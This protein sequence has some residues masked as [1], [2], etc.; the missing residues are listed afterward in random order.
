[1]KKDENEEAANTGATSSL[2]VAVIV[3][4]GV[5]VLPP[6]ANGAVVVGG[7]NATAFA[8]YYAARA[9]VRATIHHDCGIG[10]DEAGISGLP[11]ADE[12]G[13]AMAAVAT[14]SARAGD[15]EDMLDRGII[16][17]VNKLAAKCGVETGQTVAQ[18]VELLKSASWPH[19]DAEAP[20][21][22][23]IF[24]DGILCIGSLSFATPEDKGLVVASGSHG[25][26]SAAPYCREFK[27][28]LVFFNDAGF[29]ADRA[30]AACLPLLDTDGIAA[31]TVAAAS[32]RIGDGEST[33]KQG[34][35]SA[36]NETA[37]SLGARVGQP[38]F[39]I[40]KK[41]AESAKK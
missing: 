27:P 19:A 36:V 35:I 37:Y 15:A 11:W 20:T 39:D 14:E 40:A 5:V 21:E 4:D 8:A 33:L 7:S 26:R 6:E 16:S 17:R 31:A 1:M 22:E 30:G 2:N 41:V 32:A 12:H 9:G 28:R 38:A 29:G 23:R 3:K 24:I 34:I 18:A 10:R 13:M 25:G